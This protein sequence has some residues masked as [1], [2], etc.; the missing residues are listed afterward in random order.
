[1]LPALLGAALAAGCSLPQP[2]SAAS[3]TTARLQLAQLAQAAGDSRDEMA[4]LAAAAAREPDNAAA[5]LRY[6]TALADAKRNKEALAVAQPA[7]DSHK[8]DTA[9]GLLTGRL[10]LR[11]QQ[12]EAAAATYQSVLAR[13][14]DNPEAL[15]GLGIAR[16][17]QGK[18]AAAEPSFR[19][20]VGVA[21]GDTG[22]RNNLALALALQGRT[23]EAIPMLQALLRENENSRRI[24][25]N[26]ALA[27]A[28]AGNRGEA[29]AMLQPVMS[30]EEAERFL[31][32]YSPLEKAHV[33]RAG[34]A[35]RISPVEP[36]PLVQPP[37]SE[38][39]GAK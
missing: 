33:E 9:L 13:A 22:S 2:K 26:L 27:Y 35:P 34:A 10:Q 18:P 7:F 17:M 15:N 16:V 19:R 12:G 20:A 11:L 3:E 6:A 8:D 28:I 21:P 38:S 1:L 4:L 23:R 30:G 29:L 32:A 36:L 14:P 39:Q 37:E 31:A 24:R 5:Q 25:S